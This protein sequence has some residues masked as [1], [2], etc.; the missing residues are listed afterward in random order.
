M[1]YTEKESSSSS[2]SDCDIGKTSGIREKNELHKHKNIINEMYNDRQKKKRKSNYPNE[3]DEMDYFTDS[4]QI[5]LGLKDQIHKPQIKKKKN[6]TKRKKKLKKKSKPNP[7]KEE[8]FSTDESEEERKDAQAIL[9]YLDIEI[10]TMK[11][12][13]TRKFIRKSMYIF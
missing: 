2:S 8:N 3:L 1:Y 7:E 10:D 13:E 11:L 6:K 9:K 4:P 12:N 5:P